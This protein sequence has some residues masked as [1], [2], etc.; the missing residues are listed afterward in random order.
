MLR[1]L[2]TEVDLDA[3][4]REEHTIQRSLGGRIRSPMRIWSQTRF[5]SVFRKPIILL[6]NPALLAVA[7]LFR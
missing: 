3:T 5:L 1:C 7:V 6:R 2:F 4:T